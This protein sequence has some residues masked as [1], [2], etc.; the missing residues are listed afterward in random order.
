MGLCLIADR[1]DWNRVVPFV[2]LAIVWLVA[3]YNVIQGLRTGRMRAFRRN[4]GSDEMDSR[5]AM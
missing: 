5:P 3:L 4:E 1:F 2:L